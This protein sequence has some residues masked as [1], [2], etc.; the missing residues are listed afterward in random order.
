MAERPSRDSG[1][2]DQPREVRRA[3]LPRP[4]VSQE[5]F[6]VC[7]RFARSWGRRASSST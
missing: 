2:I 1:R 7:E 6:G 5:T 3:L 4:K